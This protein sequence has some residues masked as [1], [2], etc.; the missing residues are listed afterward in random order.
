MAWQIVSYMQQDNSGTTTIT[1]V[2]TNGD[3]KN[4]KAVVSV[5]TSSGPVPY[6]NTVAL[7]VKNIGTVPIV[8]NQVIIDNPGNLEITLLESMSSAIYPGR[9]RGIG[10]EFQAGQPGTYTFS[11]HL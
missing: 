7:I 8:M 11:I 6:V 9:R 3:G 4:D 10:V 2:D 5:D 1:T